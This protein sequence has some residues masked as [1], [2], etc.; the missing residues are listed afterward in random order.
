MG[1]NLP[2]KSRYDNNNY[3][4]SAPMIRLLMIIVFNRTLLV[5]Q[6][7]HETMRKF[8]LKILTTDGIHIRIPTA[9]TAR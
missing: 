3:I 5:Q 7:E 2:G 8:Y 1:C 4:T 6:Y 9:L